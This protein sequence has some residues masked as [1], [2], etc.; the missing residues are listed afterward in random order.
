MIT[1]LRKIKVISRH[2]IQ[3][4]IEE[5][6]LQLSLVFN[7]RYLIFNNTSMKQIK[8]NCINN[9]GKNRQGDTSVKEPDK[10]VWRK[11]L[12]AFTKAT[13]FPP[14][15]KSC[16]KNWPFQNAPSDRHLVFAPRPP[17]SCTNQAFPANRNNV[18]AA[19]NTCQ[20]LNH[21]G[22]VEPSVDRVRSLASN[23]S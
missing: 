13:H 5:R 3:H 10:C 7:K 9:T 23:V 19:R 16:A 11:K 14:R 22:V 20:K 18:S 8:F 2:T 21:H 12:F 4:H 15:L 17:A 6:I 1:R